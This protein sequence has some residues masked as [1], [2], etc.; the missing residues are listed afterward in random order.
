MRSLPVTHPNYQYSSSLNPYSDRLSSFPF[1]W[2]NQQTEDKAGQWR[3]LFNQPSDFALRLEIGCNTG[4]VLRARAEADLNTIYLGIEWKFKIVFQGAEKT[5][6][7]NLKNVGFLRMNAD[8]IPYVF[9]AGELDRLDIYFPDPWSPSSQWKNRII[10][11]DTLA[12]IAHALKANGILEIRT[13]N[14]E[15]AHW[16]DKCFAEQIDMFER[17]SYTQDKHRDGNAKDLKIPNI[18]LF[19]GIYIQE[20]KP[21]HEFRFRR[22]E[23]AAAQKFT[24]LPKEVA[25][26]AAIRF[27]FLN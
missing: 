3:S 24:G 1:V 21:I 22:T 9:A 10:R 5:V 19:E 4:H 27:G 23:A 6:R 2:N 17:L 12:G 13:D 26:A 25:K 14:P 16:I 8:R 18:T 15:Y 20:G 7:K 11:P